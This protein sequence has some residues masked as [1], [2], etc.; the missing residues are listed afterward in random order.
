MKAYKYRSNLLDAKTQKRRDT[1]S[2]LN[3]EFYASRF[4][5]LNDPFEGSFKLKMIDSDKTKFYQGVNP[6]DKGI[7]SLV[8]P[9]QEDI[10]PSNELMWAHY[11][12]S[13]RGFCIEY[14]LA[15]FENILTPDF[16]IR[17]RIN[18]DYQPN[19]PSITNAD[20][21]DAFGI[22]KK[23]FGTKS[24]AWSYENEIRLVFE[25]AGIKKYSDNT[26]TGIYF[27]LHIG[28][29]ERNLIVDSLKNRNI[30]FYQINWIGN[31]YQL[32]FSQLNETDLYNYQIVRQSSNH[33]VDNYNILY[34]GV[35]KDRVTMQNFVNAF[36]R[37]KSKPI[38]ITIFDDMDV[39]NCIDKKSWETT[40]Q[41][42]Q[43]LAKHWVAY[44]SFDAPE[45]IWMYP[46]R[47]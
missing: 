9:K 12:D 25:K 13:H 37:G 23:V 19:M 47:C 16:D 4:R 32:S 8:L 36:R 44:S 31:T 3:Y 30:S 15:E 20:F 27:G 33:I 7:Y 41:E 38:N 24:L 43:L 18:I 2:L 42:H 39:D 40:E 35:N 17:N 22:Q 14:E 45:T 28:I 1:D 26:I 29:D 11:A 34:N 46:E 6:I 5:D 10:F 21:L